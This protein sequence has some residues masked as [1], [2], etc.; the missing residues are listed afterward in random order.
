MTTFRHIS[1][2]AIAVVVLIAG[3]AHSSKM[4]PAEVVRVASHEATDAGYKLTDYK[5]PEVHFEFVRKDG[6]WTVL[7]ER[8]PPT[9]VGGTF[10]SLG[11]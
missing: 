9:P 1:L 3:C 8:K 10:P 4:G 11:G 5:E 6:T 2:L 7:F